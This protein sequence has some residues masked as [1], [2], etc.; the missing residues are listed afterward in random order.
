MFINSADELFTT[1]SSIRFK[2]DVRDM[3]DSSAVLRDLRPVTFR[4]REEAGAGS[5][6]DFGLIAEEVAEVA[7]ELVAYDEEGQPY[8]VRYHVLPSLLLNEMQKQQRTNAD[9]AAINEEQRRRIQDQTGVIEEQRQAIAALTT[10]LD[11]V[12][13]HLDA[14]RGA[15]R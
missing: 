4:Y 15:D 2:E 12:E 9:Q 3:A 13:R 5:A 11:E 10:R 8:S 7:P 1:P 6:R 14:P